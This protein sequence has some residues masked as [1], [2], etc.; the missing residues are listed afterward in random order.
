MRISLT[1]SV[2]RIDELMP[3]IDPE[4]SAVGHPIA[5]D[6]PSDWL[7]TSE[8]QANTPLWRVRPG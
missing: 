7:M 5:V 3:V 8:E 6:S 4:F 2:N 1:L